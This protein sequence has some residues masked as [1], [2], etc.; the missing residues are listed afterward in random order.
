MSFVAASGT[1]HF[2][3]NRFDLRHIPVEDLF[4]GGLIPFGDSVKSSFSSIIEV[5]GN[6]SRILPNILKKSG[7]YMKVLSILF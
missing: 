2:K 3:D 5:I 1:R 7:F 6:S 4:K